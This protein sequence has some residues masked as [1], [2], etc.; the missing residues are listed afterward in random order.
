MAECKELL[1]GILTFLKI[2]F[3]Y[4]P[5]WDFGCGLWAYLPPSMWDFSS[6]TRDR[7]CVPRIQRQIL[8]PWATSTVLEL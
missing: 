1:C 6:Q 5:A 8:N 2:L 7:T 3:I 4:L